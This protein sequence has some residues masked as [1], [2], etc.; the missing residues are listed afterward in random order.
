MSLSTYDKG[1]QQ[2]TF[3]NKKSYAAFLIDRPFNEEDNLKALLMNCLRYRLQIVRNS[4]TGTGGNTHDTDS[5]NDLEKALRELDLNSPSSFNSLLTAED[6]ESTTNSKVTSHYDTLLQLIDEFD[7]T[8]AAEIFRLLLERRAAI[9]LFVPKSKKHYLS[10]LSHITLPRIDNIRLSEDKSLSRVAVI[11]CRQRKQSQ[12][13]DILKSIF[14]ID[15]F[16]F[17]DLATSNISSESMLAEI[18]CG[19]I[20][21]DDPKTKTKKIQNVLVVHVMGDFRPLWSFLRRFA[22]IFLI[23]DSTIESESF[24][25]AFMTEEKKLELDSQ[26]ASLGVEMHKSISCLWKPSDGTARKKEI[27]TVNG[28]LHFYIQDQLSDT[29]KLAF[30][31][32]IVTCMDKTLTSNADFA[33]KRLKL[34][35]V[36]ILKAEGYRSLECV[37]PTKIESNINKSVIGSLGNVKKTEFVLQK[38]FMQEAKHHESKME[39][40]LKEEKVHEEDGKIKVIRKQRRDDTRQVEKNSLLRLFLSLLETKDPCSRVLSIRVLEKELAKRGEQELGE[41]FKEVESLSVS[42]RDKLLSNAD[43]TDLHSV[44]KN[45]RSAKTNLIEN[46]LGIEHLWR[47]LS[48]LYV[49]ME[50]ERRSPAIKNIPRLAAQHLMDGFCLELLDGDSN[51]IR[52]EW[53]KE[54]VHQLGSLM[55]G[56]RLF[57]LSV[58]GVQSSGKSTLLNTMF[59][60]RMRTSVGQ[61]TRGVNMQLLA[62]EGRPEYDYILLL[63]T[64][65]TRSPE[66][67]GLPGSEK[68]DNQMATLSILLSDATIVIMPGENDAAVKEIL[69]IVLMAYQGS[70]LAEDNGGRLSSRMFFVY[71]RIDTSQKDKL[72]NIIQN[73]GTSLYEAFNQVQK[74]NGIS[75]NLKSENPFADFKFD[76]TDSSESD[77]LILGNVKKHSQ[78][79]GDVPDEE[80]G[81]GL[82][83]FREHIHQRVTNAKGGN[84]FWKSRSIYEFS[85]YTEKVWKCIISANFIFTFA[86]VLEHATFDQFDLEYKE[87]ERKLAEAYEKSF[88]NIRKRMIKFIEEK[89]LFLCSTS[90]RGQD[91]QIQGSNPN[92][93]VSFDSFRTS[94]REEIVPVKQKLDREVDEM[95]KKEGRE[96]WSRQFKE[97]WKNNKKDQDLNWECN[98]LNT[99]NMLFHYEYHVEKYK[100]KM[101]TEI[102]MLFKSSTNS[103]TEEKKNKKFEEMFR[104][105]L[106]EAKN[107]FPPK[108]V[109]SKIQTVYQ[110]SRVFNSRQIKIN[111]DVEPFEANQSKKEEDKKSDLISKLTEQWQ[112]LI[113]YFKGR[114][115]L[116]PG[117]SV[118]MTASFPMLS[119]R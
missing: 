30:K 72:G 37:S 56:K 95:V 92:S 50:P 77:V 88:E 46:V 110:N 65:G 73:L 103:W 1:M 6:N 43:E 96:K 90:M 42:Y 24:F 53:I 27:K 7:A 19:C 23:E 45:L 54:V 31:S 109:Q 34:C 93:S 70:K 68:R 83:Q 33:K 22:D 17:L 116:P 20:V 89:N 80:Y 117:N 99:F 113:E 76:T 14:N 12:T 47:E 64:E 15:S 75:T 32:D 28:F 111:W 82:I 9:P 21:S 91:G 48:H 98:L 87:V 55:E 60:I 39:N 57:I 79:P 108:D 40:R 41:L 29:F 69:P 3:N 67:H 51:I 78:P 114:K 101:R 4:E 102:N 5:E 26:D 71:N 81:K 105:I 107:E 16:H 100:K 86:T 112:G 44:A 13:C 61:C 52:T 119:A 62:V 38:S 10:L 25:K 58:M 11:S 94:L 2:S 63:D 59:G 118:T 74:L 115:K 84:M 36:P 97:I 49:D 85:D 35:D 106:T 8:G 104:S 66:Y 18:G